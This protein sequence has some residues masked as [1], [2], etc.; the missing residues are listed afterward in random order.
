MC[1]HMKVCY[2]KIAAELSNS[3]ISNLILNIKVYFLQNTKMCQRK[4]EKNK[5][6]D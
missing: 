6:Y 3:K 4:K 1:L 5:I 2:N